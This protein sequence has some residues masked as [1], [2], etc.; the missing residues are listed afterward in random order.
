M[1]FIKEY[2]EMVKFEGKKT[3]DVKKSCKVTLSHIIHSTLKV[4][5]ILISASETYAANRN[6]FAINCCGTSFHYSST[7]TYAVHGYSIRQF[8]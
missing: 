2:S 8:F 5:N 7:K 3:D 6:F 1:L 4:H